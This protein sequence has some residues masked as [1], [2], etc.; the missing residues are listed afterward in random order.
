MQIAWLYYNQMSETIHWIYKKE[1]MDTMCGLNC[2]KFDIV[3]TLLGDMATCK[4][5]QS[6]WIGYKFGRADGKRYA[7]NKRSY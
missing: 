3:T 4:E 2:E 1:V 6:A 5:C 7:K